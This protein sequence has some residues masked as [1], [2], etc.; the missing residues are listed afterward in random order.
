MVV[1]HASIVRA[2]MEMICNHHLP[3]AVGPDA[4]FSL[5]IEVMDSQVPK[6]EGVKCTD[7]LYSLS[8]DILYSFP[9]AG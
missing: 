9:V 1:V 6:C 4:R 3:P 7:I 8:P 5:A 2:K